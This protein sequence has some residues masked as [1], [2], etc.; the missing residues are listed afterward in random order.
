MVVM[1]T[2]V[3]A[4]AL[5]MIV[6]G[7]RHSH[8]MCNYL[9][10]QDKIVNGAEALREYSPCWNLIWGINYLTCHFAVCHYATLQNERL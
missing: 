7:K 10:L 9:A 1:S 8:F 3:I 4:Y 6:I 2:V 5:L